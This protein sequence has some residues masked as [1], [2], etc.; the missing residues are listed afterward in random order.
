[1]HNN[2][3]SSVEHIYPAHSAACGSVV[4]QHSAAELFYD[5][6][7]LSNTELKESGAAEGRSVWGGSQAPTSFITNVMFST[8]Q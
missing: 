4:L 2:N 1:M 3:K 8:V 7:T 5:L 6:T